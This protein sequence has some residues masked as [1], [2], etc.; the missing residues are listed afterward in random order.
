MQL[1][2]FPILFARFKSTDNMETSRLQYM[3]RRFNK[4][5]RFNKNGQGCCIHIHVV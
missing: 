1:D 2:I 4:Y 3:L 5:Q